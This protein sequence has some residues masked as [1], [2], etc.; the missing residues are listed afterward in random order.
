M[1]RILPLMLVLSMAFAALFSVG[2]VGS[3]YVGED[4]NYTLAVSNA[5]TGLPVAE[6]SITLYKGGKPLGERLTNATGYASFLLHPQKTGLAA[7]SITKKGYNEYVLF[8]DIAA[9]PAAATPIPTATP[10]AVPTN[11]PARMSGLISMSPSDHGVFL[12]VMLLAFVCLFSSSAIFYKNYVQ[13]ESGNEAWDVTEAF[14]TFA[15]W[16]KGNNQEDA[17]KDYSGLENAMGKLNSQQ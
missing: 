14:S 5:A 8:Q 6:A 16:I 12:L 10:T 7:F 2:H 13:K 4:N 9:R 17:S 15:S 1:R 3:L 11:V